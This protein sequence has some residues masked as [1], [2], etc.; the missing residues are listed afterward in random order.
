MPQDVH[1]AADGSRDVGPQRVELVEEL[2][3]L[4]GLLELGVEGDG[5]PE[6]SLAAA[7]VVPLGLAGR[8]F[9]LE[10]LQSL[11][12]IRGR[13]SVDHRA[14]RV[15]VSAELTGVHHEHLHLRHQ[16]TLEPGLE[17]L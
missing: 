15:P 7:E 8:E 14:V 13:E 4:L 16:V 2:D 9:G 11:D 17:P 10:I 12:G 3:L 5:Q 1:V 6:E